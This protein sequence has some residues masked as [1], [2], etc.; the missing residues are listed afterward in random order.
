MGVS[1]VISLGSDIAGR[2]LVISST[3]AITSG[4][5]ISSRPVISPA[6]P[7]ISLSMSITVVQS[8]L[9]PP[10]RD[11]RLR[12]EFQHYTDGSALGVNYRSA[13][14]V[15]PGRASGRGRKSRI[16]DYVTIYTGY[17]G[18]TPHPCRFAFADQ[19]PLLNRVC[20]MNREQTSK[21][22]ECYPVASHPGIT[23]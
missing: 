12:R 6:E 5:V 9:R 21:N 10:F 13:S 14:C 23:S 15:C 3:P 8:L 2:V 20:A 16:L 4:L 11:F 22:R 19:H 18:H 7:M 1:P 17:W